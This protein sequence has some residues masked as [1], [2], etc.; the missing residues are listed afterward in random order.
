[1]SD[2][3][4]ESIYLQAVRLEKEIKELRELIKKVEGV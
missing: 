4:L 3:E 2:V 1:M